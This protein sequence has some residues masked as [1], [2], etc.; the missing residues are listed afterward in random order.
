MSAEVRSERIAVNI[1]PTIMREAESALCPLRV[2][3]ACIAA[4]HAAYSATAMEMK[5]KAFIAA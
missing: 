4:K 5:R 2:D 1:K 3:V